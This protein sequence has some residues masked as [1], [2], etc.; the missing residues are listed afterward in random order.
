MR[1]DPQAYGDEVASVLALDG[2]GE[3]LMPLV[4]GP[5][6]SELAR[7]RLKATTARKLFPNSRAP[8]A[9]LAGLYLYFSCWDEAHQVAQDV[10]TPEGSFW[11]AIV[12]RQEPDSGNSSYWFRQ[13][14]EHPVFPALAAAAEEIGIDFGPKW[15][16][17]AFI[18]HCEEARRQPGSEA[19]RQALETQRAE[20]QL[21]FDYCAAKNPAA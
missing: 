3:R 7:T 9:A 14:G 12:H 4:Q 2:A 18:Q 13:A 5:C 11:H 17:F 15:D 19:E 1:F 10:E 20:W 16:P 21:L 6:S 8:E